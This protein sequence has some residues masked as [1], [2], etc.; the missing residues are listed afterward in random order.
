MPRP[1][2]ALA[3]LSSLIYALLKITLLKSY[4]PK[5]RLC[6]LSIYLFFIRLISPAGFSAAMY[7]MHLSLQ[8]SRCSEEAGM[9]LYIFAVCAQVSVNAAYYKARQPPRA[10]TRQRCRLRGHHSFLAPHFTPPPALAGGVI[11]A[12]SSIR[13]DWRRLF[14]HARGHGIR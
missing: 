10:F 9:S 12:R 3:P 1:L 2:R 14:M 8:P 13:A 4:M 5:P 11:S 7:I 6:L